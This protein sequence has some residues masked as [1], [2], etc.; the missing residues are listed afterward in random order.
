MNII[1]S[2]LEVAGGR[3]I[4]IAYVTITYSFPFLDYSPT[5]KFV[6]MENA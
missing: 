1:I 3:S 6:Q 4:K 5:A 2:K